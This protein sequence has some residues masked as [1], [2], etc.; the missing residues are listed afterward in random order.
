MACDHS[1]DPLALRI[2]N[3][4]VYEYRRGVR[5]LFLMT[6]GEGDLPPILTRLAN[7]GIDH[8]VQQ[9]TATKVNLFFGSRAF[10]E[11]TRSIVTKPLCQLS[12]EEDFMLGTML[13]YDREQQCLRYLSRVLRPPGV[14]LSH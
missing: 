10:V 4:N 5:A 12:P 3:H 11:T 13:G 14:V 7:T 8:F 6:M 9:V 2:F 1:L